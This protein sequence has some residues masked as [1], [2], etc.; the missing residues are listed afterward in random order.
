[1]LNPVQ[2][3]LTER[4]RQS[5]NN[6]IYVYQQLFPLSNNLMLVTELINTITVSRPIRAVKISFTPFHRNVYTCT[7]PAFVSMLYDCLACSAA[8]HIWE[9]LFHHTNAA[10]PST[11]T[12]EH[13][14]ARARK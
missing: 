9:S 8:F 12:D 13:I 2:S 11:R 14:T 5:H 6:N 1:M 7:L 10:R 4:K 3:V